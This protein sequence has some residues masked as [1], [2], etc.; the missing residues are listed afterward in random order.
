MLAMLVL[1]AKRIRVMVLS[2]S[3]WLRNMSMRMTSHAC[4]PSQWHDQQQL[5][6]R[7]AGG[8]LE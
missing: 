2:D 5:P 8:A 7:T 3:L 6:L 4:R 1:G